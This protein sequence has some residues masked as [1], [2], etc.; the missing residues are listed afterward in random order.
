VHNTGTL[1]RD[2]A[3]PSAGISTFT[4]R[5][6]NSGILHVAHGALDLGALGEQDAGRTTVDSGALL[7]AAGAHYALTGGRLNG[8]GTIAGALENT[9]GTVAP[10]T[11]PGTLTVDGSYTQG[12]DGTLETEIA[13]IDPGSGYDRLAVS[14]PATLDGALVIITPAG[15]EPPFGSSYDV[16][17]ADTAAGEFAT[18][19]G[20]EV[21]ARFFDVEYTGAPGQV[22]LHVAGGAVLPPEGGVPSI[23]ATAHSGEVVTC[24]PGA[25][26][27]EPTGY[28]FAWLRNG[29]PIDGATSEAYT[30]TAD[31]VDQSI[32]CRVVA[33]NAGGDSPAAESN[34][35]VPTEAPPQNLAAPSI[36]AG[37]KTGDVIRCDPGQWSGQPT[38]TFEWLRDGTPIAVGVERTVTAADVGHNLRCRVTATNRGGSA[39]AQSA[40]VT[41]TEPPSPSPPPSQLPVNLGLPAISGTP[42]V[43]QTL[44]CSSG[45]W[46]GSP[47]LAYRWLRDETAIRG[48]TGAAY[49]VDRRDVRRAIR[50][51]VTA[52]NAAGSATATSVAVRPSDAQQGSNAQAAAFGLP[53]PTRCVGPR[54]FRLRLRAPRGAKLATVQLF[55]DGHRRLAVNGAWLPGV[56]QL[57]RLPHGTFVVSI[58]AVT[59][60]GDRLDA[61]RTYR[62]CA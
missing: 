11:S 60:G 33:R 57:A 12:P 41:P 22:R 30:V 13:G 46:S 35:L 20:T 26:S 59:R 37:A 25:W 28:D 32:V 18:V 3:D 9:G 15:F 34:V 38:F 1:I 61:A 14:G 8:A 27:G 55:V 52:R 24:D 31:D 58:R 53:S 50:C 44:R 19:T 54:R 5:L 7:G 56:V 51:R 29:A 16:I 40:S 2:D 42:A 48:A 10:G 6:R 45:E 36:P 17:T 62:R 47:S 4:A 23:P 39:S 49:R 43:G 21:G